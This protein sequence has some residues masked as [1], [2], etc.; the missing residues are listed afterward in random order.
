MQLQLKLPK[1]LGEFLPEPLGIRLP[2]E[3][4]HDIMHTARR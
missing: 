2:L 3:S 1:P 4:D